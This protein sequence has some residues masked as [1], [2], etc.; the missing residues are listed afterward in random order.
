[1]GIGELLAIYTSQTM[2]NMTLPRFA[3]FSSNGT[4]IASFFGGE[5]HKD[6][7]IL[8]LNQNED[9]KSYEDNLILFYQKIINRE[10]DP[11]SLES[12]FQELFS[13]VQE[14]QQQTQTQFNTMETRFDAYLELFK[15]LIELLDT[16][17]TKL[18]NGILKLTALLTKK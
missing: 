10:L 16:R 7:A 9:P 15:D 18:E 17:M 3:T 6:M 11:A 8:L 14:N 1:M 4:E 12:Q 2:G 13:I 5:A